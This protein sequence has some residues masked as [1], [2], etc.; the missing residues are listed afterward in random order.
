MGIQYQK[1]KS[2]S[3]IMRG[4]GT[5]LRD[6]VLETLKTC[7]DLVGSTLGPGGRSV[8]IE[9]QDPS[10]PPIIT[11]DGVTVFRSLGFVDP[12]KQV[13]MEAA[14]DS[15]VRTASEA[16]DGTTTATILA[17]AFTRNI[18]EFC[19]R[20]PHDSP[21]RVARTVQSL[22]KNHIVPTIDQLKLK[23]DLYSEEGKAQLRAVA[24]ISA[25]GD[26][27]LADAVMKAFEVI[28]DAG[29]VTISEANGPS[30]YQVQLIE[31]YPV[32]IG[33]ED[34]CG[35]FYQKFV[36][37]VATQQTLLERPSFVLHHGRIT[38][39]NA[40]YPALAQIANLVSEGALGVDG[41]KL[42]HNVVLVA[43]GFSETVLAHLAAGFVQEGT[44]NIFPLLVPPSPVKTGQYD[45]LQD[46]AAL[47]GGAI[48]DPLGLPLQNFAPE[49]LGVGPR[50]FE[51]TRFRSN[52]I[53][54]RDPLLVLERVDQI[55]KQ[56]AGEATSELE[57]TL[58]RERVAKLT[59]GIAKIV[60]QGSSYGEIKE[61]RDRVED[62]ICA[63]REAIKHGAL[64]GGGV[65]LAVLSRKF[66]AMTE[67]PVA[68]QIVAPALLEP[69]KRLYSNA[70]YSTE[71]DNLIRFLGPANVF[72]VL[73]GEKVD[74]LESGILD[75]LPA[76]REA[77]K[78]AI[79]IAG[80]LGTCGGTVV[81]PRD[82]GL[83]RDEARDTAEWLRNANVNEANERL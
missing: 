74:P 43:T 68:A 31:G 38:D 7:S 9:H 41:K 69:V 56:L 47:T 67:E 70:G 10:M 49:H 29:N 13:L 44:L 73:T 17:E 54:N 82:A 39:F 45:F 35:P 42:T 32:S 52:V 34:A 83:E 75:S 25:N 30:A 78:N 28:G 81:F 36:N 2:V 33:Y 71:I 20:N 65:T 62:A 18:M 8:I 46:L 40:I 37:D 4:R 14:R 12:T 80:L 24:K 60:V 50:S 1:V 15:S 55:T 22:Y 23:P 16:G 61:R 3:K 11:K 19:D 72:D 63:V 59:S 5:Q 48:F 66:A 27:L 51:A 6:S 64:P 58:L 76:V 26:V 77:I 21:Q 53:G 57:K 79:S